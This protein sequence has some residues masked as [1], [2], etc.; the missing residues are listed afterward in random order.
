MSVIIRD[1]D[2]GKYLK[3]YDYRNDDGL[4]L[5]TREPKE[6]QEFSSASDLYSIIDEGKKNYEEDYFSSQCFMYM[7]IQDKVIEIIEIIKI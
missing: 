5:W 2:T 1:L 7:A 3:E 4:N 6:A